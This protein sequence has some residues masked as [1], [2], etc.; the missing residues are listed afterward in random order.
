MNTHRATPNPGLFPSHE[1]AELHLQLSE[2]AKA[3]LADPGE[4]GPSWVEILSYPFQSVMFHAW[5]RSDRDQLR[6]ALLHL[7]G[8]ALRWVQQ[9]ND[10]EAEE[11]EGRGEVP[12]G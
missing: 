11:V 2:N 3:K 8:Q 4:E 6:R 12:Q 9:L 1:R 7:Q 10:E 5:N